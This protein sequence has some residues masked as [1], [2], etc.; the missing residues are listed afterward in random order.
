MIEGIDFEAL[1]ADKAFDID[2]I[3]A[4]LDSRGAMAVIPPKAD[5]VRSIPCDFAM[6]KWRHLVENFFCDLKPFRRNGVNGGAKLVHPGGTK[7]VHLT[8][9]GTRCWGVVPVV[10]RRD[11]RCF[12]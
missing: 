12:V 3:R 2:W 1:L 4:E 11:P 9:C 7:L 6:Y 10:H 8:L 5:R